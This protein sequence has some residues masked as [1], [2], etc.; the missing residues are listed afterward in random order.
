[1]SAPIKLY[2]LKSK[3]HDYHFKQ[4]SL[5][6]PLTDFNCTPIF[7]SFSFQHY[8]LYLHRFPW[9]FIN[10]FNHCCPCTFPSL[11]KAFALIYLVT[12]RLH[13]RLRGTLPFFRPHGTLFRTGRARVFSG[14]IPAGWDGAARTRECGSQSPV[15]YHLAT[16]QYIN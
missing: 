12:F 9:L 10:P 6:H 13:R 1:M 16:P 11:W 15:P 5:M 8:R 3:T 2:V 4:T 14:I 7:E